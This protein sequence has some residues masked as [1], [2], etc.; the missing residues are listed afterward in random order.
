ME[1]E[2]DS[3]SRFQNWGSYRRWERKCKGS[4]DFEGGYEEVLKRLAPCG[5]TNDDED[6]S[7]DVIAEAERLFSDL[8]ERAESVERRATTLQGAASI[9]ATLSVAGV[10]LF[11]G[12][13][14]ALGLPSKLVL[15]ISLVGVVL[16]LTVAAY[17]S[18]LASQVRRWEG[19]QPEDFLDWSTRTAAENRIDRAAMLASYFPHNSK[20]LA[21][22]VAKLQ[23]ASQ[24]FV[25]AL[26]AMLLLV[27][28]GSGVVALA[29]GHADSSDIVCHKLLSENPPGHELKGTSVA[30]CIRT[31]NR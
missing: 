16:C 28:L 13:G 25:G 19:P 3:R 2:P 12:S 15:S 23:A 29:D 9:A 26:I 14:A 1:E 6:R 11:L 17:K 8:M 22:K 30:H 4:T 5:Q 18:I 24:W 7:K 21:F 27:V 31:V 20:V 10:G